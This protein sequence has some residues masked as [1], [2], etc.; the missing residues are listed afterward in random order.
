MTTAYL[1][2]E[3]KGPDRKLLDKLT[4]FDFSEN[5]KFYFCS[6]CGTKVLLH[7]PTND[8]TVSKWE[9]LI[10]TLEEADTSVIRVEKHICISDTLD[11]GLADFLTNIDGRQIKR[12]ARMSDSEELPLG[13]R[14]PDRPEVRVPHAGERLHGYCKCK[15]VE[16]WLA[17]P[18][19][20]SQHPHEAYETRPFPM[21]TSLS[22]DETEHWWLRDH[23]KR[24][25]A[26]LC[27]CDSCRLAANGTAFAEW[28]YLP[29]V[30][31]SLD[32]GGKISVP[33]S[34]KWGTIRHWQTPNATQ[35]FCGRCGAIIFWSTHARPYLQDYGIGLFES[36]DGA[37]AESWFRWRT[38][39]L[40][41]R[42]DGL[43]RAPELTLAVEKG[44][45]EY[46]KTTQRSL[47]GHD[48]EAAEGHR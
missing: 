14:A 27:P 7:C 36:A 23:G 21:I 39:D 42:E 18:S 38:A 5:V 4:A 44:L 43:R 3:Y 16:L 19:A 15:G 28:A 47:P 29:T 12:Y 17:A 35:A 10:G 24:F 33:K 37:R 1:P 6:Q 13:W 41:H 32:A 25:R 11:G 31:I 48:R 22:L 20:R 30:D 46:G 8:E 40:R 34:L 2:P 26:A 9:I 45:Q